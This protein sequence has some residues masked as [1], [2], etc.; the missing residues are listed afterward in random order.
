[1]NTIT[2]NPVVE[3]VVDISTIQPTEAFVSPADGTVADDLYLRLL[4]TNSF[5]KLTTGDTASFPAGSQ[6]RKVDLAIT[7]S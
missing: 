6:V 2:I 4:A 7:A 3:P 1:M 5:I